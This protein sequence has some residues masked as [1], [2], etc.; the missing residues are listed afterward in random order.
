MT[1]SVSRLLLP[2]GVVKRARNRYEPVASI[3]HVDNLTLRLDA[4][5]NDSYAQP[6]PSEFE[7][8]S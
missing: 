2:L 3:D 5:R 7:S 6:T 4:G 1:K 8:L